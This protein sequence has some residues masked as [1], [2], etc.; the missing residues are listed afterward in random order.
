MADDY[1]KG[2]YPLVQ[3]AGFTDDANED[4]RRLLVSP[5]TGRLYV[6]G[7]TADEPKASATALAVRLAPKGYSYQIAEAGAGIALAANATDFLELSNPAGS[8]KVIRIYRIRVFLMGA[9]AAVVAIKAIKRSATDTG[10]TAVN[11]PALAL[12]DGAA[13]VLTARYFTANPAGLGAT[14]GTVGAFL[15]ARTA[16]GGGA[17]D[18]QV[19]DFGMSGVTEPLKIDAG[20]FL[21]ING[22]GVLSGVTGVAFEALW[23]EATS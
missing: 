19:I 16:S 20:Q 1:G 23:T 5:T 2:G 8:G 10:G 3:L 21:Y 22:N 7:A 6:E 13:P 11:V 15:I 14:I 18:P 12:G 9:T 17:A 4:V